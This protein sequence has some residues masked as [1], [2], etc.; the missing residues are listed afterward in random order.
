MTSPPPI[1]PRCSRPPRLAIVFAG[2][3]A[4]SATACGHEEDFCD[5]YARST[6]WSAV[7]TTSYGARAVTGT[8]VV[9]GRTFRD[10]RTRT[11]I[12]VDTGSVVRI[13]LVLRTLDG[14][15]PMSRAVLRILAPTR[16]GAFAL[17]ELEA[18]LLSCDREDDELDRFGRDVTCSDGSG[19]L[20][21]DART[22]VL[23]GTVV[24]GPPPPVEIDA[25]MDHAYAFRLDGT[26]EDETATVALD[27]V[28]FASWHVQHG[29]LCGSGS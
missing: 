23:R 27:V 22:T 7:E 17:E 16:E 12:E 24:V 25:S 6:R 10:D 26:A 9:H 14:A 8:V 4:A 28:T 5:R 20:R 11:D 19:S 15:R 1:A 3:L 18:V 2:L 21:R 13:D 29:A